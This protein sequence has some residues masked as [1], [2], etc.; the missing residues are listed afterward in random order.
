MMLRTLLLASA[1]LVSGAPV[2]AQAD[3]GAEA[4]LLFSAPL[5]TG[6]EAERGAGE[7]R[8]L[9]LENVDL[10][11]DGAQ[12]GA[13]RAADNQILAWGA[14]GNLYAQRGTLSFFWRSH[15]PIGRRQFVIFRVGYPDH[16]SWDMTFLRLDWNGHGFDAFVTDANLA[17]VRVSFDAPAPDKDRWTHFALAWDE[18]KGLVLYVNG[19][20]AARRM[21]A[22]VLDNAL[23]AFGP[24]SRIISGYQVQSAYDYQRGGDIDAVSTFDH[25]LGD[26][27]VL[28]LAEGRT[29]PGTAAPVRDLGQAAWRDEWR[30]RYGFNRPADPPPYLSAASTRIAT[31]RPEEARDLKARFWRGND[32][33]RET[34]WPGVYNRS[35]LAGRSDYFVLPDWNVY[36]EGGKALTLSLPDRAW[37]RIE[38]Q[39]AADGALTALKDGHET[40][41][42]VRP[43][44]QERTV[45][46]LAEPRT[47]GALRFENRLQETPIRE[48]GLFMV[49]PGAAP[50]GATRLNYVVEAGAGVDYP[51]LAELN[52]YIAGRFVADERQTVV[53]LPAG[54]P[55]KA[56]AAR[57]GRSM[58][59]VHVLIPADFRAVAPGDPVA[60]FSY[61]WTNMAE[62]L[63]GIELRIPALR[64]TATHGGLIPL[65]VRIKDPLWP[66]R[67]LID[68]NVSVKPGEAR[69]LFLDTRDR[70]LP[71]DRSV[72]LQI[73]SASPDFDAAALDGAG[74]SLVFKPREAAL[75]EHVA[76]REEQVRG[77]LAQFVEEQPNNKLLPV[78]EQFERDVTDLLRADPDNR[79]G[80]IYWA[81]Q[82]GDQPPP[83]FTQSAPTPG[84]PLWAQRQIEDLKLARHFVD[85]WIDHRQIPEGGFGGGLSD[86]SDLLH[87]WPPIALMGL[88]PERIRASVGATLDAI[89]RS[90]MITNGL[91]TIRADELHSYEEGIN[92]VA[93]YAL[94]NWGSPRAIEQ[95]MATARRYDDLTEVNPAGHRHF[96]SN[97]FAAGDMWR[98]GPWQRQ[99]GNNFLMFH[100]GVLL[101]QWNGSPRTRA[102]IVQTLDGFLAHARPAEGEGVTLP[103]QI[104]W[105]SDAEFE[106]GG[107]AGNTAGLG[108]GGS[109]SAFWAAY[110]WTGERKYLGPLLP[111]APRNLVGLGPD[112]MT[113][114]GQR[115]TWGPIF[116]KA[117][118][119]PSTYRQ[120][121][122]GGPG[123][124]LALA[125]FGAWQTSGDKS[126]LEQLYSAEIQSASQ[127]M[128]MMTEG[129]LWTDRVQIPSEI[130]QRSRLGGV[131]SRR[132]QIFPGNRVSW[133]FSGP[134][135]AESVALLFP[136]AS[137][138]KLRLIAYN[139]TGVPVEATMVGADVVPGRWTLAEGRDAN[140]DDRAD[141]P[142]SSIVRFG[143]G[144]E[145]RLSLPP[146]QSVIELDLV[147]AGQPSWTRPDVGIDPEDVRVSGNRMR[148]TVHGLGAIA[149][150]AGQVI[151]EA[152][153]R[154]IGR[155]RFPALSAPDDLRP[156]T[157][158]ATIGLPRGAPAAGVRVRLSLD[159]Q[160]AEIS[161]TNNEVV[162][163]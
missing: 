29:T 127:R 133:R 162:L 37:N 47:G 77:A 123:S 40:R 34:T 143:P 109:T 99:K 112:V 132:G 111:G 75:A 30:L 78:Y 108:L 22:A 51:A 57:A 67:D 122:T 148:V 4:G 144:E 48:I 1:A 33:V 110:R 84:V 72:Y 74:I 80:R 116:E 44:G 71:G 82:N 161:R 9:F 135:S 91:N 115:E 42:G 156:K 151:V 163:K 88:E 125:R 103:S 118:S 49:E 90:G 89:Y 50:A 28:A 126:Y 62:G 25:M 121:N 140:Q 137:G 113:E 130:L 159:G 35:R 139:L 45:L 124:S 97:S 152:G 65:N 85:W 119:E 129:E 21:Q 27:E 59:L 2:A 31:V 142:R 95:L 105:P 13:A 147:E 26:A 146:G 141:A 3:S 96:V 66:D 98:E 83:P 102:S 117:A 32:G 128:S 136:E 5:D 18:A 138:S 43:P 145:T 64:A 58:P 17:R 106:P 114:L 10:V 41:I 7:A 61:G 39:G 104:D 69:T 120:S 76:D 79:V 158:V 81:E 134:D 14:A 6:F 8:P 153:G 63:D 94:L 16:T 36:S 73:A 23:Y 68:V 87:Q 100:P 24:H 157:A 46:Q 131:A 56:R 54:A 70:L 38:I 15:Q 149:S 11:A 101:V 55:R 150:P 19:R 92:T 12:G 52:G 20:P 155:G 86:D 154:E 107:P 53:A 93:Q 160:P 60:R